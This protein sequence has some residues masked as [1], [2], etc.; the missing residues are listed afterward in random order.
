VAM[1]LHGTGSRGCSDKQT[2]N[3]WRLS[4]IWVAQTEERS[5]RKIR[6]G[7]ERPGEKLSATSSEWPGAETRRRGEE[8]RE[9]L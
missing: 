1:V 7:G 4:G 8:G 3:L 6:V 5:R 2:A 9:A